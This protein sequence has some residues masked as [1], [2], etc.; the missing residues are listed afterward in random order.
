MLLAKL[1]AY[2]VAEPG[3]ALM[4]NYL[5]GGSQRVKVEDLIMILLGYQLKRVFLR[6]PSTPFLQRAANFVLA[7]IIIQVIGSWFFFS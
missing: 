7:N 5:T 3:I 1:K 2:G 4:S 6:G